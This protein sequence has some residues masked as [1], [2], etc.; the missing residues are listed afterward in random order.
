[1]KRQYT[2]GKVLYIIEHNL[3]SI[4]IDSDHG[5]TMIGSVYPAQGRSGTLILILLRSNPILLR[6][7]PIG[8]CSHSM[9]V[10]T[11]RIRAERP[12]A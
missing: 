1:M 5:T 10:P 6:S 2:G 9:L 3:R 11:P 8:W 12:T 7:K 4:P